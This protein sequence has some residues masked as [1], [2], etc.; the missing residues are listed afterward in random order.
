MTLMGYVDLVAQEAVHHASCM[1]EFR[2]NEE[3]RRPTAGR[4]ADKE[5]AE[6]FEKFCDH[7]ENSMDC[8]I[9]SRKNVKAQQKWIFT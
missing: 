6:A 7:F 5:M 1:A 3:T 4:P 9:Y 2:L 8:E